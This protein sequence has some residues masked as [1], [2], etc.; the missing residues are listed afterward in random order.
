MAFTK[1]TKE[2]LKLRMGLFAPSG[3]GKTFTALMFAKS[4]GK[5]IAYI[6]TE[7]RSSAKYV[8]TPGIPEFDIATADYNGDRGKYVDDIVGLIMAAQTEYDVLVL[9]S[10]TH[11]WTA[12]KDEVDAVAKRM[13]NPNGFMAW[14]E[15]TTVWARLINAIVGCKCHLIVCARSKMEYVQEK[16]EKG[17]TQIRKVGM[18]PELRDGMEYELDIV[19]DMDVDHTLVVTKS[20]CHTVADMVVQKPGP[21]FM[22]PIKEWLG[23][24]VVAEPRIDWEGQARELIKGVA[25][26]KKP[27]ISAIWK[28]SDSWED[29]CHAI[30]RALA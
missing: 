6:D 8:G 24:G 16:D 29:K 9:D 28:S 25:D 5:R 22:E 7:N 18:A 21:E 20:R 1:A 26:E 13:K 30:Q 10:L 23:S 2:Q 14:R 3:G 11:A 4:L 27:T 12:C 19:G 17:R 15:G